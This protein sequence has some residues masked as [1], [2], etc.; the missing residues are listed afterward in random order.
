MFLLIR[1]RGVVEI[2]STLNTATTCGDNRHEWEQGVMVG[3][4]CLL[5]PPGPKPLLNHPVSIFLFS[6]QNDLSSQKLSI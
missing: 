4:I 1:A 6:T 5:D 2:F 3:A